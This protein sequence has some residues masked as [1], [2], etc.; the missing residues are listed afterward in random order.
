MVESGAVLGSYKWS[1]AIRRYAVNVHK[2]THSA[3]L[4]RLTGFHTLED[5]WLLK[6]SLTINKISKLQVISL[7]N[8]VLS[9]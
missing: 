9:D 5:R 7:A 3:E 8:L 1:L 2:F 4:R 6:S